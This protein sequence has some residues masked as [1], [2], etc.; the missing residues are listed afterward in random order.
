ME[1]I[2][3]VHTCLKQEFGEDLE[4]TCLSQA[5]AIYF[6]LYYEMPN[7]ILIDLDDPDIKADAILPQIAEDPWLSGTGVIGV[8]RKMDDF[9]TKNIFSIMQPF[10]ISGMLPHLIRILSSNTQFLLPGNLMNDLGNTG[11]FAIENK[12]DILEAHAE[13]LATTLYNQGLINIQQKYGIKFSLVE[14]LMNAV[15]HGNCAISYEEKTAWL[16]QGDNIIDLIEIKCRQDPKIAAKQVVLTYNIQNSHSAFTIRDEGQGFDTS[17]LANLKNIEMTELHGRGIFMTRHYMSQV[18]YNEKGNEVTL[19]IT[20]EHHQQKIPEGFK[21]SEL[22]KFESGEIVFN[23]NDKGD[24]LFYIISGEFEV[25]ID[26]HV[27]NVLN[28]T[29]VFLGEM[30]FLLGN[31]RT[32]TV[33][34]KTD[35]HLVSVSAREWIGAVQKYPHYGVFLARLIAKKLHTQNKSLIARA[36][37]W[38]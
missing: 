30:A 23:K 33:R 3:T 1:I 11:S 9:F 38:P 22:L 6:H 15:E 4:F 29:S 20:H 8:S 18:T 26:N 36:V 2:N 10:Q 35:A 25:I 13:L 21:Q 7:F 34:A 12:P 28:S 17:T 16:E 31:R 32:A 14:M 27:V 37:T 24:K 19:T 5:H